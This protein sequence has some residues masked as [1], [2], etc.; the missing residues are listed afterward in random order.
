MIMLVTETCRR[1]QTSCPHSNTSN[2]GSHDKSSDQSL[3]NINGTVV[4]KQEHDNHIICCS[5]VV[6]KSTLQQHRH[7][8]LSG[9]T[10]L[11]TSSLSK[12]AQFE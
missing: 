10:K 12:A 1:D 9:G 3:A 7:H 11:A 6:G 2:N 8:R 4:E 5:P